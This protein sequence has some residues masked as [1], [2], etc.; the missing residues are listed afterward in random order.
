M[1][2]TIKILVITALALLIAAPVSAQ[3]DITGYGYANMDTGDIILLMKMDVGDRSMAKMMVEDFNDMFFDSF[4]MMTDVREMN[5]RDY[6][7]KNCVGFTGTIEYDDGDVD[8]VLFMCH[9]GTNV[10]IVMGPERDLDE[11]E[12]MTEDFVQDKGRK[13]KAAPDGYIFLMEL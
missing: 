1:K 6:S 7:L 3:E 4:D 10:L 13:P 12:D 8:G 9:S 5:S 2:T 11:I